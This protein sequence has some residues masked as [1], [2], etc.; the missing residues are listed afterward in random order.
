MIIDFAFETN[1]GSLGR[2]N[3]RTFGRLYFFQIRYYLLSIDILVS[4]GDDG[5]W[6]SGGAVVVVHLQLYFVLEL[7]KFESDREGKD[8]QNY[9]N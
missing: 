4:I 3:D 9:P 1:I 5:L 6:P 2:I 7:S 8:C